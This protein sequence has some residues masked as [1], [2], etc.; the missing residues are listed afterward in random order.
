MQTTFLFFSFGENLNNHTMI[1]FS[2]LSLK[3][4]APANSKFLLYTDSP[5]FYNFI[6]PIIE[7]RPLS[8]D[9]IKNWRGPYDFMW[10]IKI[11]AM[12]DSASKDSGHLIYLDGDT[13]ATTNLDDLILQLDQGKCF[14]HV[15]ESFLSEDKAAHKSLMWKQTQNKEYGGMLVKKDSAMWNAGIVGLDEKNKLALLNK[16]L[17]STDEMC[18]ANVTNWLIEQFSLSQSLASS[19]NLNPADKWFAHY[20]GNKE[21]IIQAI[22]SFFAKTLVKKLS[23]EEAISSID[24]VAWKKL[25]EPKSKKTFYQKLFCK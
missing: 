23:I 25:L 21:E 3:K 2:L 19:G 4:F 9:T 5:N 14:M 22:N 12:I 18:K 1:N 16:A 17:L 24:M 11:M 20:W 10:R 13:F 7:I 8:K 15:E 6:S